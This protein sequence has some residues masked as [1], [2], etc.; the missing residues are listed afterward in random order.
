MRNGPGNTTDIPAVLQVYAEGSI[1]SRLRLLVAGALRQW[2]VAVFLV[3]ASFSFATT[4]YVAPLGSG[5]NDANPGTLS[6]P[7]NT[8]TQASNVAGPGDLVYVRA[9]TYFYAGQQFIYCVGNSS[10]WI[11][12][13]AYPDEAAVFD[14]AGQ[15]GT[16]DSIVIGGQYIAFENF[17]VKNSPRNGISGW[18]A[19]HLKILDI[20]THDNQ[21]S[22]IFV[23]YSSLGTVQDIVVSD[24]LVHDNVLMNQ[25]ETLTAWPAALMV[26]K[27]QGTTV[28]NNTCY[29]NY[30]EG[31]VLDLTDSGAV[32]QNQLHDN[33]AAGLYLDNTTK[34]VVS[35]NFIYTNYDAAFFKNGQPCP[36]IGNANETYTTPNPLD[37]NQIINNVVLHGCYCLWYGNFL[38][39]GG[40]R[41]YVVANNVFY[42]GDCSTLRID[43]DA[44]HVNN[45]FV[46]N[47][48][49]QDAGNGLIQL[50][51]QMGAFNFNHNAWYNGSPGAAAGPGDVALPPLFVNPGAN[52]A[53]GYALQP[54]SP[55]ID[56]G[57]SVSQVGDDYA[58]T[59]RP[60]GAAYDIGA[61]EYLPPTS[62]PTSTPTASTMATLTSPPT[63]TQ[64]VTP[65]NTA[66]ATATPSASPTSTNSPTDTPTVTASF[67]PS[68]PPSPAFT[69]TASTTCTPT[70]TPSWTSSFT[71]SPTATNV[72]A[73]TTPT[74]T[75]TPSFPSCPFIYPNPSRDGFRRVHLFFGP[76]AGTSVQIRILTVGYHLARYLEV[77]PVE[78]EI[79]LDL[80]DQRGNPLANGL[81]YVWV[82]SNQGKSILKL[83]IAQ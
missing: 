8:L 27:C 26:D 7:F 82:S 51:S 46:N 39:G 28:L 45:L 24:C 11:T 23:G 56:A 65:T 75:S 68:P 77:T 4:W 29:H 41:D 32:V 10:N 19:A 22:G 80:N 64:T 42:N 71:P 50:P 15:S 61:F 57:A 40:L 69:S 63:L 66:T 25:P 83:L 37:A 33:Y 76:A 5:G 70:D 14:F 18:G 36:G 73:S 49:Y 53:A 35:K 52:T 21:F 13:K 60:Q 44:G 6:Q 20:N 48:I 81:Y 31:I 2:K 43:S 79:I 38:S 47:I 16:G 1:M 59:L 78:S 62:T 9:G 3:P 12:F 30:G 58:G 74:K 34:T 72:T 55:L 54:A 67:T 17:E